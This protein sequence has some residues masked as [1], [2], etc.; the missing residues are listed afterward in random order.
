MPGRGAVRDIPAGRRSPLVGRA[1]QAGLDF[2]LSRDPVVADYPMGWG[3][4]RPSGSWFRLGFPS[5]YVTDV[6]QNLEVLCELGQGRDARLAR[7]FAWLVSKRDANGRWRN[8]YA[9]NR[10]TWVDF[11]RQ[12]QPSKWV[13]LR[14]CRVLRA[15]GLWDRTQGRW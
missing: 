6:L 10:K 8:E 14:A 12:G 2:L 1:I 3:N 4:V 13:S 15:S 11:E 7:A 9:Y 5:G